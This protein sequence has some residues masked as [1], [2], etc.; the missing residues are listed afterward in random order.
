MVFIT[1]SNKIVEQESLP[2]P[3]LEEF[4]RGAKRV[5][6][7][8]SYYQGGDQRFFV[9]IGPCSSDNEEL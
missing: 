7:V 9:A 6:E 5:I 2:L 1:K 4:S 8:E 3:N